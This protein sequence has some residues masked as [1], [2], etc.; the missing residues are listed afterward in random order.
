[1]T[2]EKQK[3][4]LKDSPLP[5]SPSTLCGPVAD[6]PVP[7][8]LGPSR[9]SQPKAKTKAREV[10]WIMGQL[11]SQCG[12][13]L[14]YLCKD[15]TRG[16][17]LLDLSVRAHTRAFV[18]TEACVAVSVVL[19]GGNELTSRIVRFMAKCCNAV[20]LPPAQNSSLFWKCGRRITCVCR[21]LSENAVYPTA[22]VL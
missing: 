19:L 2:C 15:K 1:M 12:C 11:Q 3:K 6:S 8:S 16:F 14:S 21:A 4:K 5:V 20:H 7:L 13:E 18:L 17:Y 10:S 22:Q 9:K